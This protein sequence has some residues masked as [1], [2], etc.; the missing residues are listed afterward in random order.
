M[1]PKGSLPMELYY[2][3]YRLFN[4]NDN[5]F[6]QIEYKSHNWLNKT[7]EATVYQCDQKSGER[8]GDELYIGIRTAPV[9]R[10]KASLLL[11]EALKKQTI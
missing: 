10:I 5:K 7:F 8:I 2:C 9:T 3:S 1:H 6:Y 4:P 11:Q